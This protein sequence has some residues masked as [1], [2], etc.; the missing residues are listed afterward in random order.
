MFPRRVQDL[1]ASRPDYRP[2]VAL[3]AGMIALFAG[4]LIYGRLQLGWGIPWKTGVFA[5]VVLALFFQT[6]I[7]ILLATAAPH[8][9][10][11]IAGYLLG[12]ASF[13]LLLALRVMA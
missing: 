6:G 13:A 10:T 11:R 5:L 8:R 2:V 4:L 1:Q 3:Y 7:T 9:R 12:A